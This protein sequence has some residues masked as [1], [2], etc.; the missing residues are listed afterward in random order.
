MAFWSYECGEAGRSLCSFGHLC[1]WYV[2]LARQP[3]SASDNI[4]Q[5]RHPLIDLQPQ[6]LQTLAVLY[7]TTAI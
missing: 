3:V 1:N 6:Y 4:R 5:A 7:T 2:S